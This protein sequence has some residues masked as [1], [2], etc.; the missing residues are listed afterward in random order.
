M[1][2]AHSGKVQV[3]V[4]S[5]GSKPTEPLGKALSIDEGAGVTYR[6]R[7]RDGER[8]A[9][10]VAEGEWTIWYQYDTMKSWR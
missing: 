10:R 2:P 9:R 8:V 7:E 3:A 5:G 1:S 6:W 4:V